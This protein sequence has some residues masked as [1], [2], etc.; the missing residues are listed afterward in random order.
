[1]RFILVPGFFKDWRYLQILGGK[2]SVL[3]GVTVVMSDSYPEL[4]QISYLDML[5]WT[6][7]DYI[8]F[9]LKQPENISLCVQTSIF[10]A[11]AF[12]IWLHLIWIRCWCANSTWPI[13]TEY[14]HWTS[15]QSYQ[16]K[17]LCI[18]YTTA[19]VPLILY[20]CINIPPCT[21]W[22]SQKTLKHSDKHKSNIGTK[23]VGFPYTH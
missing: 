9:D 2:T 3:C 7:R 20:S 19:T 11:F 17:H 4:L 6:I 10:L 22:L 23:Q 13:F 1:M 15:F 16:Y 21:T 14:L 5:A 8:C 12:M 18:V